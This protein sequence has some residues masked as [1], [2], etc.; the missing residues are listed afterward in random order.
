METTKSSRAEARALLH[1]TCLA[2]SC[3]LGS[4]LFVSCAARPVRDA[5]EASKP[6]QDNAAHADLPTV[7]ART[8]GLAA[9]DGFLPAW[10]DEA[11]GRLLLEAPAPERE[12][13]YYVSLPGGLGSNDVGLD[14]GQVGS[15]WLVRFRRAGGRVLLTA[16]NLSWRAEGGD[17][18]LAQ[19]VA[20]SFAESVLWGF[21]PVARTG[22]R[23]LLDGTDFLLRDAHAVA[24]K[25][26][27]AGQGEFALDG[28]R[29]AVLF[30]AC[31]GFEENTEL[32]VLQTFT[33]ERGGPEVRATS[34][35]PGAV[36]LRVRHSFVALPELADHPFEPRAFDPR[37][38]F[39]PLTWRDPTGPVDAPLERQVIQRHRLT[40]GH[41][42]VYH[43]D[44]TAPEPV[45]T[46]LLEG[47]RYWAPVFEAAGYPGGFRVGLLP[48]GA[49]PQ[50]AR[51][52][53]ITWVN[54]S[55][56]GWSYGD[57]VVDPRTGEILKGHVSL[58][59]LRVRQDV[60]ILEGLL[61]PYADGVQSSDAVLD[62]ALARIR[63]LAAHEVGHTLG[64]AHNFAASVDERA[65][66][67][68]YPP[69]RVRAS[70]GEWLDVSDAYAPG[71]GVWDEVAIRYGYA[72]V[73]SPSA[74]LDAAFAAG[75]HFLSDADARGPDRAHPLANL[76]DD[77]A[78]PV[79]SLLEQYDVRRIALA[80][81]SETAVKGGRP[82]AEL[83]HTLV[84]LWLHHRY[85][86]EA[87]VRQIGGVD[88]AYSLRGV[89]PEAPVRPVGPAAQRRAL[90]VA[91][92]SLDPEFLSWPQALRALVPPFPPGHERGREGLPALGPL[93]D[94]L[95]AAASSAE[96]TLSLLL[97]PARLARVADQ[98]S[99]VPEALGLEELLDALL[100]RALAEHADPEAA[101]I[102]YEVLALV[103]EH[104]LRL[105]SDEAVPA[106]V[107]A[108]VEA[109][110]RALSLRSAGDARAD[111][112]RARIDAWFEHRR[113]PAGGWRRPV[114]PPG[115]PIGCSMGG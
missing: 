47:A 115:S 62:A 70:Q 5:G 84:P 68:D 80:R 49:D 66:V 13:L 85:Q 93:L 35:D 52:N 76:W 14:R 15:R 92:A 16:P 17:P 20:E 51:W 37:C 110:L 28:E 65:S 1:A 86:L 46:A 19:G 48:E 32:E 82:L 78:D 7:E 38:G 88:Y 22:E 56:R 34:A 31:K 91:L 89:P 67:M 97:D 69:P 72:D 18:A 108:R 11:R 63:Q 96:L 60:L 24:R 44:R 100:E 9:L 99:L 101:A 50:D 12:V 2:W 33:S 75:L 106:R 29:C 73:A 55:T 27:D 111:W 4:P 64:L 83:E 74:V 39:F 113:T 90:D 109:A 45:R 103:A 105:A 112:V 41:P 30:E 102:A 95:G 40:A 57:T 26:S 87:A 36:T 104:L 107:R 54:R 94:P 6:P 71:C 42:I 58:G 23:L 8:E 79:A 10:W 21:E 61:A 25:L 77:G 59:A 98:A 3:L 114:V 43:V 53:V 81:F